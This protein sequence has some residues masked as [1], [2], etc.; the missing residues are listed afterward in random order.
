MHDFVATWCAVWL[1]AVIAAPPLPQNQG[2]D[3]RARFEHEANPVQKA[4]LL[5]ALGDAEFAGIRTDVEAGR[6]PEALLLLRKYRDEAQTCVKGLDSAKLDADKHPRGFKQLQFSLQESLRRL[7]MLL[8]AMT[9]DEQTP[10]LEVRKDLDD[11]NRHLIE[12]LF[13]GKAPEEP[14]ADK[15]K[16]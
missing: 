2:A 13:P 14:K 1:T 15:P 16:E 4:K 8:V 12:Q 10:F 6:F 11:M 7:D 5:P 9:S 3:L